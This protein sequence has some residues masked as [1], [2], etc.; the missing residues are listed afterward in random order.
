MSGRKRKFPA[1]YCV[2]L[3]DVSDDDIVEHNEA[4]E[5]R[6][7]QQQGAGLGTQRS[8]DRV[9]IDPQEGNGD[10]GANSDD[11]GP[12][13]TDD[14][15]MILDDSPA[16]YAN[17]VEQDGVDRDSPEPRD[18]YNFDQNLPLAEGSDDSHQD[19]D[20]DIPQNRDGDGVHEENDQHHEIYIE[21]S[22]GEIIVYYSFFFPNLFLVRNCSAVIFFFAR[23]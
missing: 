18:D 21:E 9:P 8:G 19:D 23:Q 10:H 5:L 16:P 13:I 11:G 1:N 7:G 4:R 17:P 3:P 14:A 22:D 20:G 15:S 6:V 12:E 2:P